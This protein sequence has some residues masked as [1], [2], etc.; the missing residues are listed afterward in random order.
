MH[1]EYFLTEGFQLE[2]AHVI[3]RLSI[4]ELVIEEALSEGDSQKF[5]QV[6]LILLKQFIEL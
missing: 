3:N 6:L 2:I 1:Q 4:E 5:G